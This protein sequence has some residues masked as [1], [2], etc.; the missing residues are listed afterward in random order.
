MGRIY[1]ITSNADLTIA[2]A[3]ELLAFKVPAN[4]VVRLLRAKWT[5]SSSEDS[6]QL[7]TRLGKLTLDV[8]AATAVTEVLKHDPTDAADGLTNIWQDGTLG[9]VAAD[10]LVDQ[11]ADDQRVGYSY[12]PTPEEVV[13]FV[14]GEVVSMGLLEAPSAS[15]TLRPV[16]IVEVI[17]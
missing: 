12:H 1:T 7:A 17:G 15:I 8:A 10:G 16:M 14:S 9:T 6:K 13:S 3:K 11:H 5:P 2:A 4:K